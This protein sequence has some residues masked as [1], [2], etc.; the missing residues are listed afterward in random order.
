MEAALWTALVHLMPVSLLPPAACHERH[1]W[2]EM[3]GWSQAAGGGTVAPVMEVLVQPGYEVVHA[4]GL[5]GVRG[6]CLG[7]WGF[8]H[9]LTICPQKEVND[10]AAQRPSLAHFGVN[11]K[12]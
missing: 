6:N 10:F 8:S 2:W 1:K 5:L 11:H 9:S 3:L 12:L 4:A 7:L